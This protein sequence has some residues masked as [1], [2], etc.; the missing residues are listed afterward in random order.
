MPYLI[1][2]IILFIIVILLLPEKLWEAIEK[3]DFI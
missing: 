3:S 2:A 1:P